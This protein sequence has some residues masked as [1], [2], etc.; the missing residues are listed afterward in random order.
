MSGQH[1]TSSIQ[2]PILIVG[3]GLA[4]TA[5][6]W[7]L[8]QRG[9]RFVVVDP[10]REGT[11]SKIAA[12]L[13]TPITGL[14]LT[15]SPGFAEQLAAAREF[16][17]E[18]GRELRARFYHELPHVRLFKDARELKHW[19]AR[20]A[21]PGFQE[22][23]DPEAPGPLV[24]ERA[25]HG[26]L[27]GI[28]MRGS[29]WL[30]TAG[31]LAAS[32]ACFEKLGCW[33]EDTV[34]ESALEPCA[35]GVRW[36]GSWYRCAVFCRGADERGNARFFP[37]LPWQCARGVIATV[38]ADVVEERIVARD[39]WMLPRDAGTWRAGSTYDW[40]LD[41][42]VEPSIEALREKLA[43]LLRVPFEMVDTQAGVRP[44]LRDR[45]AAVGRHPAHP[46]VAMFNGLGSKGALLAPLYSRML[47]EH[48]LDGARLD[49]VVDV[50]SHG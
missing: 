17:A 27:G 8:W 12:G 43:G 32:R 3:G 41:A 14:R 21:A 1:P 13:V 42:P 10:G 45:V 29:G 34:E 31:Y 38:K 33:R 9:E 15:V 48:L 26:E 19:R 46:N 22:W 35:E 7:R 28:Q 40:D 49:E 5:L 4:G 18:V 30:D 6:G 47:V 50:A 16:Y 36:N 2:R 25:F 11:S 44:I 23:L 39:G 24:D 37:W 20:A